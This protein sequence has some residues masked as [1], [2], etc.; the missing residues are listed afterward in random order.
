[1]AEPV[2]GASGRA[3]GLM[4]YDSAISSVGLESAPPTVA[5]LIPML[6]RTPDLVDSLP[7]LLSQS[8]SSF[9][10]YVVDLGSTDALVDELARFPDPRIVCIRA[11]RPRYFSFARARNLGARF[12][13]EDL[14][15]FL[16]ADNTFGEPTALGANVDRL[17]TANDA[18]VV[19][20]ANWRRHAGYRTL[21]QRHAASIKPRYCRAYAHAFGAPL[22]VERT[23]FEHLGGYDERLLDWGYEDT[24]LI[25]RLE[26]IGFGRIEL[27]GLDQRE[28]ADSQRVANF[29]NRNRSYTW[30]RNRLISEQ[31][32]ELLGPIRQPGRPALAQGVSID[33]QAQEPVTAGPM[34]S[35]PRLRTRVTLAAISLGASVWAAFGHSFWTRNR[36]STE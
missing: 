6:D 35:Q 5:V 24:D 14:L 18:D 34:A 29:R 9:R 2:A 30:H 3:G 1:M 8:Y 15:L 32:L 12:C 25:G 26:A 20:Y 28:H 10:I 22:L 16:N 13:S 36:R 7:S 4:G 23:V 27:S 21:S 11:P 17:I 31:T 33:G 19:W